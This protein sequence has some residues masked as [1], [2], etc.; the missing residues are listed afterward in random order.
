M[1][2]YDA[3]GHFIFTE[4]L[5]VEAQASVARH[6]SGVAELEAP[7]GVGA[8]WV[9]RDAAAV[10]ELEPVVGVGRATVRRVAT[11]ASV[12]AAVF[13]RGTAPIEI[14]LIIRARIRTEIAVKASMPS[15][16]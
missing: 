14:P 9:G 15:S 8:V 4:P 1:A 10:A 7:V 12:L 6:S 16:S 13:G 5:E 11:G 2:D 3:S